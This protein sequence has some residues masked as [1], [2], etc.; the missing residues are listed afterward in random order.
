VGVAVR[1]PVN[2]KIQ[3]ATGV[4]LLPSQ[5]EFTSSQVKQQYIFSQI[6][7]GVNDKK[8]YLLHTNFQN[9]LNQENVTTSTQ[10]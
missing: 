1:R 5:S 4:S 9:N 3:L 2:I 7:V 10:L 6:S 8:W